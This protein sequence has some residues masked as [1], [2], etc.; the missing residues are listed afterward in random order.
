MGLESHSKLGYRHRPDTGES[1]FGHPVVTA[2]YPYGWA[3]VTSV[4]RR[5]RSGT[6]DSRES[7]GQDRAST[8]TAASIRAYSGESERAQILFLPAASR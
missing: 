4:G 6:R 2:H 5:R 8:L 7:L 1:S 3:T